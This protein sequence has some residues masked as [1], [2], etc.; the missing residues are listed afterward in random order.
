VR[1][2][3]ANLGDRAERR[4]G[5]MTCSGGESGTMVSWTVPLPATG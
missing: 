5:R 4:G 2:G 3:L 1:S